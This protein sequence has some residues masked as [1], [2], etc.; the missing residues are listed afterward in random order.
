MATKRELLSNELMKE[1][2]RIRI[3]TLWYMLALKQHDRLPPLDAE[4]ATGDFDDK[5]ALFMPGGFVFQDWEGNPIVVERY[6]DKSAEGFRK[7][8]RD[9]MRFD[10]VHLLYPDGVAPC[11]KLGNTGFA[12]IA[13]SILE[14]R[15]EAL[16]RRGGLGEKPPARL[17][18]AD[19][20]RSY[21][22]TYF[23]APYGSRTSL[24][25]DISVCLTEPRMYFRQ[26]EGYYNLRGKE[27]EEFWQGIREGRQPILGKE[28]VVLAQP[29]LVTCHSTRYREEILTGIT[30]ISG[31]GKFGELATFT[32]EVATNEL[33]H[34]TESGRTQYRRDEIVATHRGL[35]VV[36]VLRMYPRTNPG[37]RLAKGVSA[38][39]VLPEKELGLDLKR[40][41]AEAKQRYKVR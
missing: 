37:A 32:L 36:G 27:A 18:S 40:I 22:P 2:I 11:V 23:P 9:V 29:H 41:T 13:A 26:A 16:R 3:D 38:S 39:L 31:F 35:Q 34:E 6:R 28:D 14:N 15:K 8:V 10:G 12:K 19:I 1:I 7:L 4:K 17:N 33:L 24:S 25:S 21:C 30:R 20:S 5:G